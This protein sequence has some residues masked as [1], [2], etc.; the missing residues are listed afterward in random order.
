MTTFATRAPLQVINNPHMMSEVVR[1]P[2]RRTSKRLEE[3]EGTPLVNGIGHDE[4]PVRASQKD[5]GRS[6]KPK[7]NGASGKPTAKRKP[8]PIYEEDDNG[9]PFTRSRVK[10]AR[11]NPVNP[12]TIEEDKPEQQKEPKPTKRPSKKS[13]STDDA[14]AEKNVEEAPRRRSARHSDE[15]EKR[16]TS[17]PANR[18]QVEKS[19]HEN[20]RSPDT[21]SGKDPPPLQVKKKRKHRGSD[22]KKTDQGDKVPQSA[23]KTPQNEPSQDVTQPIEVTFDATKIAL[24]FADTPRIQRN[25]DM[26][27]TNAARRS[28]LGLRGR[29]A[30]SLIDSGKSA[31]MPHDEVESSEFYKHIESEGLSEPR[32]MK[33]LLTWCGTRAMGEKPSFPSEDS[34]ARLAAREIQNQLLKDF[35]KRSELSDWFNRNESTPPPSL[36]KPNPKNL[37]N[38]AKIKDLEQQIARL[39]TE[40]E[41]WESLLQPPPPA[42]LSLPPYSPTISTQILSTDPTQLSALQTLHSIHPHPAAKPTTSTDPETTNLDPTSSSSLIT[43]TT[44]RLH[45]LTQNLEFQIDT[46]A[47]NVHALNAYG[48]VAESIADEV[49]AGAAESLEQREREGARR[50]NEDGAGEVG[51][52]D[53]LRG[54]SR[55]IDRGT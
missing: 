12:A 53:V 39:R 22:E 27:K 51:T 42:T 37:S 20:L 24:P 32:R 55:V 19:N 40:R 43:T 10:K 8:E 54:L 9:F 35:Q 3:K 47:H 44:S 29:R 48:T 31:A 36:P 52:R 45:T 2:G 11:A 14:P 28:S 23:N 30:S 6:G 17:I 5:G 26:R 50:A 33:Q 21:V 15:H 46:L 49:L 16:Q 25:K 13:T 34:N 18:G 1:D 38:E 41:T 7:V 4:E